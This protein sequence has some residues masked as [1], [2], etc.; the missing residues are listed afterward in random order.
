MPGENS[1]QCNGNCFGYSLA[2][3][4]VWG[5][6]FGTFEKSRNFVVKET[7]QLKKT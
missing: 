5:K 6:T 1:Y 7:R 2:D 4:L 3:R